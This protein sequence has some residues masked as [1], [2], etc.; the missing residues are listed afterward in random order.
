M[1]VA[2]DSI[3]CRSD[4]QVG[5]KIDDEIVILSITNS[6]YYG[7]DPIASCIWSYLEEPIKVEVIVDRVIAEYAVSR[8]ECE[9]DVLAFLSHLAQEGLVK[10]PS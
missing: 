7:L 4:S 6:K 8:E 2:L 3:L 10:N 5:S 1:N 9:K